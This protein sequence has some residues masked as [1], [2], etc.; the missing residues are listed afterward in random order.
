MRQLYI[1]ILPLPERMADN[2]RRRR[3]KIERCIGNEER[4]EEQSFIRPVRANLVQSFRRNYNQRVG[5]F[6]AGI[7]PPLQRLARAVPQFQT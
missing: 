6:D 2:F 3:R 1:P 4:R 5:R 7:S